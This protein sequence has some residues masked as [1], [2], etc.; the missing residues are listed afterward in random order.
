MP[1]LILF[2][3]LAIAAILA[4]AAFAFRLL[5]RFGLIVAVAA[6]LA[7]SSSM[8]LLWPIP[9]H[10]GF[11]FLGEVAWDEWQN[12]LRLKETAARQARH[13]AHL[14]QLA[15]RFRGEL[16][17]VSRSAI[18]S[19]WALVVTA[20]GS[21]GWHDLQ[22]ALI[23][24]DWLPLPPGP[25]QPELAAARRPCAELPP[26]GYWTLANEAERALLARHGD[27]TP[28]PPAPGSMVSYVAEATSTLELPTYSLAK[29]SG[30]RR[31]FFV[32]CVARAPGS[33][34]R[35]YVREDIPLA[36]WNRYQLGKLAR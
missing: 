13:D 6:A 26:A 23:W 30:S 4:A 1:L 5:R 15:A 21:R 10:G 14:E 17:V 7:I 19:R 34:T 25:M 3:L 32:Q 9:I 20:E 31:A 12:N 18:E 22:S 28:V 8:L 24:S 16:P 35:G 33:P 11:T 27:R 36:E 29:P 2:Y